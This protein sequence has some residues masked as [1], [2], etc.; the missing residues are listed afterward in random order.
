[1][2]DNTERRLLAIQAAAHPARWKLLKHAATIGPFAATEAAEIAG[3]PPRSGNARSN[4]AERLRDAR[5]L[6]RE[7][8]HAVRYRATVLGL[9][10]YRDL[11]GI[12]HPASR[13]GAA[14]RPFATGDR[15]DLVAD[16]RG[17]G[18][19]KQVAPVTFR[20]TRRT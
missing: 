11:L 12:V 6:E 5:L 7:P 16:D 9:A 14:T 3:L 2:A 1:V 4:H 15:I 8:G 19:R 17:R 20:I 10:F 13:A 18:R